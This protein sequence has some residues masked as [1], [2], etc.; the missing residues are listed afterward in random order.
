MEHVKWFNAVI[1]T[2]A[3]VTSL[4]W[5][6][7]LGWIPCDFCWYERICMY[8]LALIYVVSLFQRHY[9]RAVT[10]TLSGVGFLVALYHYLLQI[11]P[12]LSTTTQCD[13]I[14]SCAVP[15]FQWLGF[16]TPPLLAAAAFAC[17][18]WLDVAAWRWQRR[19]PIRIR[20][21]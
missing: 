12:S 10:L 2:A 3:T 15:E 9:T 13:S 5:S 6:L 8:P 18:F 7:V 17:L 21:V 4:F 16:V 11:I 19:R 14:V 1:A 20:F